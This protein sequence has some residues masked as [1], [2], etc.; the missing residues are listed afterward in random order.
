MG[1]HLL[2]I[3]F[4]WPEPNSSAAG[5][6]MLQLISFFKSEGYIITFASASR[7]TESAFNLSQMDVEKRN[8]K[9]NDSSFDNFILELDPDVVLFDRFMTEEQYGWRVAEKL[10]NTIRILDTEDL[11]FLRKGRETAFKNHT[12]LSDEHVVNDLTKREMASIYRCDLNLIISKAEMRLLKE[13]FNMNETLLFYLPFLFEPISKEKQNSFPTFEKRQHFVTIGN[14]LHP[15]NFDAL[16]YLKED[17]WPKIRQKLPKAEVHNYGSYPSQKVN[18][19]HDE[20]SGFLIKG[21]ALDALDVIQKSRVLLAPLRFGAGLKGK[22]F[23]AMQTGTPFVTTP[24]GVEGILDKNNSTSFSSENFDVFADYAV[25]LFQDEA[26]WKSKQQQGFEILNRDFKKEYF[27]ARFS[28][29]LQSLRSNLVEER[30]QN[31]IGAMLMHHMLQSTKY[32]S[33]WIAGKNSK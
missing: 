11:H 12:E 2:I 19:L 25:K 28:E 4:V 15:P 10:P 23:E 16:G 26:L 21:K 18:Q 3:G 7:E 29:R 9:L 14:F 32:L 27:E 17:I 24:I 8:I 30:Y 33:K 1:K 22:L 6:R 31:F 20:K 5:S 13:R